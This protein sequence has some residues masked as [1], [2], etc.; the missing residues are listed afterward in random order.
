MGADLPNRFQIQAAVGSAN[1]RDAQ[2][3]IKDGRLNLRVMMLIG[4]LVVPHF[5]N[6]PVVDRLVAIR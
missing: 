5:E 2:L 6:F 3:Q 1:A 4:R